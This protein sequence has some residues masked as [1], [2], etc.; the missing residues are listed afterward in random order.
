MTHDGTKVYAPKSKKNE[1]GNMGYRVNKNSIIIRVDTK[2]NG[3]F[4]STN[5]VFLVEGLT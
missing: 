4:P 1:G 2:G 5:D 3:P